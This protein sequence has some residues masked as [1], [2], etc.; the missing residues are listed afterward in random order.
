[1][2]INK[3]LPKGTPIIVHS[4]GANYIG[5]EFRGEIAGISVNGGEVF[6]HHYIV[7]MIDRFIDD[8]YYPYD[9]ITIT[10]SCIRR[11]A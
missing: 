7:K 1:M 10:G 5:K 8:G 3:P 9:Y 2:T 6:P 4:L 11:V